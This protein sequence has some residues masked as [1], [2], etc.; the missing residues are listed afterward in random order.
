MIGEFIQ[1]IQKILLIRD[2]IIEGLSLAR[3]QKE[4]FASVLNSNNGDINALFKTLEE[5]SKIKFK[6][7]GGPARTRTWDQYIMS[8]LL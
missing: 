2:L 1:K 6:Y 8:V 4:E 3:T 7:F 5:F